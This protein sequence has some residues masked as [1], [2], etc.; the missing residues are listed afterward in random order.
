[1]RLGETW[2]HQKKSVAARLTVFHVLLD[3]VS[4]MTLLKV[5]WKRTDH[6][7]EK[8]GEITPDAV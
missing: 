1:M 8:A 4:R 6:R 3:G 2:T 7:S 5:H